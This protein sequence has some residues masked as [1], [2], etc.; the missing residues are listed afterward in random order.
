M[1]WMIFIKNLWLDFIR[2]RWR[3]FAWGRRS[4]R[5][6]S[7]SFQSIYVFNVVFFF[8]FAAKIKYP[9]CVMVVAWIRWQKPSV[10][11]TND[12]FST[13]IQ[14]FKE[15]WSSSSPWSTH[16]PPPTSS[17]YQILGANKTICIF[18]LIA[19]FTTLC[20][21]VFDGIIP[22]AFVSLD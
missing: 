8:Y 16:H 5:W 4:S 9:G 10:M 20:C 15:S 18:K 6:L 17:F 19:V 13:T 12:C 2:F 14:K 22:S 7:I 21:T 3:C 11:D 1:T